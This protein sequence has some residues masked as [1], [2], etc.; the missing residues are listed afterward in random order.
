VVEGFDT[1]LH[2]THYRPTMSKLFWSVELRFLAILLPPIVLATAVAS[3]VFGLTTY[4]EMMRN[5]NQTQA[6]ISA[7]T[8]SAISGPLWNFDRKNTKRLLET[9]IVNS[10]VQ[11]AIV[12]DKYE[13]E[14]INVGEISSHE[15]NTVSVPISHNWEGKTYK[16]GTLIIVFD[17]SN[18]RRAIAAQIFRDSVYL[19]LLVL[20]VIFGAFITYKKVIRRPLE[21]LITAI[22][23]SEQSQTYEPI[24]WR[25]NDE[26]G[27]VITTYNRMVQKI[28]DEEV[29]LRE[30]ISVAEN[31]REKAEKL[32]RTDPLTDMNNRRA[33]F[34]Y[35]RLVEDQARR[36]GRPYSVIMLDI[37]RFKAV[38]DV[39]GHQVGDDLIR[40]VAVKIS[41]V[42]RASDVPGRIGGEEFAIILPETASKEAMHL[43]ERLR[44]SISG[45][46]LTVGDEQ[47]LTTASFGVAEGTDVTQRIEKIIQRAD[48]AM[49]DSK[50]AGRDKVSLFVSS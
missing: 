8:V 23:K 29:A 10:D 19:L 28:V 44:L 6:E 13:N 2:A 27:E 36:S 17:G 31:E 40:E 12:L 46:S 15:S 48:T 30:A 25:S 1:L 42:V 41:S 4:H 49:Y 3:F 43:A 39:Y 35:G 32:A 38:N 24:F 22:R 45:I 7:G 18:V 21:A 20:F 50:N 9:V 33:F 11:N 34:D 16:L 5:I 14:F 37:D 26:L 47:I